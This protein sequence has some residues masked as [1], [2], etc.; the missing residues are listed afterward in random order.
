MLTQLYG[1]AVQFINSELKFAKHS[2]TPYRLL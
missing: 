1:A 2:I